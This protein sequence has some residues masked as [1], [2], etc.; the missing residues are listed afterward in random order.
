MLISDAGIK[1]IKSF[2]GCQL[3]A[4]LCPAKVWTIGYGHT[5]GVKEGQTIT[6]E[7]AEAF[8]LSDLRKYERY[9]CMIQ[10]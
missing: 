2:E 7:A 1:L 6:Q 5:E 9:M 10:D 4:Y 3:E 8:L